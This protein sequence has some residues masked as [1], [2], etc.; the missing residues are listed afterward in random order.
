MG[1]PRLISSSLRTSQQGFKKWITALYRCANSETL[2]DVSLE[3]GDSLPYDTTYEI[4]SSE[5]GQDRQSMDQIVSLRS[6]GEVVTEAG[7]NW[8]ELKGTRRIVTET[9]EY[10]DWEVKF[11]AA[12][13]VTTANY[14]VPGDTLTGVKGAGAFGTNMGGSHLDGE[15]QAMS[16]GLVERVTPTKQ[17]VTVQ[18]RSFFIV[19]STDTPWSELRGTRRV[20]GQTTEYIDWEVKF[21][22]ASTITTADYPVPGEV[23]NDIVGTGAFGTNIGGVHLDEEPQVV[24]VSL[25]ELITPSKR[26]LTT[27]FRAYCIV[28]STHTPWKELRG[29]RKIVADTNDY[30]D[31]QIAFIG[32]TNAAEPVNGQPY[33]SITGAGTLGDTTTYDVEPVVVGVNL[34]S[35]V[36]PTKSHAVCVFRERY[37]NPDE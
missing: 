31:W 30:R 14:P 2:S 24:G 35:A 3:E 9:N 10:I 17:H 15:P 5:Q 13:T 22:G 36:T 27:R 26:H 25:A 37:L 28:D 20:A 12:T 8:S 23:M 7:T 33:A 29:T 6:Y 1:D 19:D 18:F 32:A 4:V 11:T 21:T 34:T 16:I